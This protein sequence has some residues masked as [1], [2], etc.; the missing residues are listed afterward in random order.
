M[1][2]RNI[3]LA[4]KAIEAGDGCP[5]L[6]DY[7]IKRGTETKDEWRTLLKDVTEANQAH[8]AMIPTYL[9]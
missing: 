7:L 8:R 5:A 1:V 9:S 6:D 3:D 4:A 2:E